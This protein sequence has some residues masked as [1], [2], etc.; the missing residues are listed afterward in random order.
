M[1]LRRWGRL[2]RSAALSSPRILA[3]RALPIL[4]IKICRAYA[5]SRATAALARLR[6]T[7]DQSAITKVETTA[8]VG[9]GM[10]TYVLDIRTDLL[11]LLEMP[12][13][14]RAEGVTHAVPLPRSV[15]AAAPD[16]VAAERQEMRDTAGAVS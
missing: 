15:R 10:P 2:N 12:S 3:S 16:L 7:C 8:D 13:S 5:N 14:H 6:K 11:E 4:G 9:M 1:T